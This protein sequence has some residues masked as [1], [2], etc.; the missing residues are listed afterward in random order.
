MGAYGDGV[1][2]CATSVGSALKAA[3][4]SRR[5]MIS[6][7]LSLAEMPYSFIQENLES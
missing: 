2:G 3:L 1:V 7:D 5:R 4:A 6:C